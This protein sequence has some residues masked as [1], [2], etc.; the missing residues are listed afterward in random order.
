MKNYVV[1]A[2][3]K[4]TDKETLKK[5]N[6]NEMFEVTKERYEE[7]KNKNAIELVRIN[8]VEEKQVEEKTEEIIIEEKKEKKTTK[9]KKK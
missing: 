6:I 4:F 3:R 7:L 9:K 5:I 8:E 1:K 2:I